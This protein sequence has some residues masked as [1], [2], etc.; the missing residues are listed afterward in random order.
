MIH[1]KCHSIL[2]KNGLDNCTE[3]CILAL[4]NLDSGK[5]PFYMLLYIIIYR[6]NSTVPE[7]GSVCVACPR[8]FSPDLS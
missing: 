7:G 4:K 2:L 8:S 3:T 6:P 5:T 1:I